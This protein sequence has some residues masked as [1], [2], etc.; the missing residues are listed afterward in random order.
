MESEDILNYREIEKYLST[1]FIGRDI[2]YFDSIDSTN[3]RAKELADNLKEGTVLIAEEQTLGK[4]RLER[5][6][7]SPKGKGIWMS[8]FLKSKLEPHKVSRITQIVAVSLFKALEKI[9]IISKIKWPNDILINNKKVSGILTEM[10]SELN[11]VDYIIIGIGVNVNLDE[12]DIPED[13]RYKAT[14][15]KIEQGKKV[16]RKKLTASILNEFEKLYTVFKKDGDI[17]GVIDILKENSALIGKEI[18][19]IRGNQ[20]KFGIAKDINDKGELVVEFDM[21]LEN[22]SSGEVSIRGMNGYI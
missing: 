5:E 6:W 18:R 17:S 19:V 2:R 12:N 10:T 13:L 11:R 7:I 21:G 9:D 3:K 22:I 20:E 15:I 16:D 14:S 1:E 4:G 8:I